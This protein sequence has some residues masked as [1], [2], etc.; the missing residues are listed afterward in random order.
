MVATLPGQAWHPDVTVATVVALEGRLLLVE[1]RIDGQL[2]LNQPAGHLEPGESLVEAAVRETLEETGWQVRLEAFVGSYQWTAPGGQQYLRFA[3]AGQALAH[4]PSRP[5]MER[6]LCR[7][8]TTSPALA[9][10]PSANTTSRPVRTGHAPSRSPR[11]SSFSPRTVSRPAAKSRLD[12]P[13]AR[14]ARQAWNA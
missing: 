8:M 6:S 3:F 13:A 14:S 10:V 5:R 9:R 1:E 4:D 12:L 2:V 7:V 11:A